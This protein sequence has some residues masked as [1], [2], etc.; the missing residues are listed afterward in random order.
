MIQR[1][2][3]PVSYRYSNRANLPDQAKLQQKLQQFY[4][5]LDR[6]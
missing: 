2:R 3:E 6:Y 4:S 1:A 5:I